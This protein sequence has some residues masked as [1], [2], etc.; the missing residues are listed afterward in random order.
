MRTWIALFC[1]F[2]VAL[3]TDI[4]TPFLLINK[5]HF[6]GP[7]STFLK[8][9]ALYCL[10]GAVVT[11]YLARKQGI[12]WGCVIAYGV[13][14]VEVA[15]L[16][17]IMSGFSPAVKSIKNHT[18]SELFSQSFLYATAV[19]LGMLGGKIGELLSRSRPR[20]QP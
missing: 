13:I 9:P 16:F 10:A 2:G 3:I 7:V 8:T 20:I 1:G 11:G 4:V 5:F 17:L 18:T 19:F 14:L 12:I 15:F 6:L